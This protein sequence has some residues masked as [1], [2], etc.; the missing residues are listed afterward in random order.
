MRHPDPAIVSLRKDAKTSAKG[1]H[2]LQGHPNLSLL[3]T[4]LLEGIQVSAHLVRPQSHAQHAIL[5]AIRSLGYMETKLNA[6]LVDKSLSADLKSDLLRQV[7]NECSLARETLRLGFSG[8]EDTID[9]LGRLNAEFCR[10]LKE[11]WIHCREIPEEV[12]DLLK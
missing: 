5:V 1:V 10:R 9:C 7:L 4:S 12:R 2:Q 11:L 6:I 3:Q 8:C